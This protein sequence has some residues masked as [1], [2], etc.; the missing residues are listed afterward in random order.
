MT[1]AQ[2]LALV[3]QINPWIARANVTGSNEYPERVSIN[4]D[5]SNVDTF[6]LDLDDDDL[7]Y[8]INNPDPITWHIDTD[9]LEG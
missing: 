3:Q 2:K 9:D 7:T 6:E 1:A 4:I 5:E 8:R